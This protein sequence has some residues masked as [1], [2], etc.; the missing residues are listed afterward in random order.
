[1][2]TDSSFAPGVGLGH[3]RLAIIDLS[4]G[5]HQPKASRDG[6]LQ[7]TFNGEI[8]NFRELRQELEAKGR[9]FDT[10]SDTE[11]ILQAFEEWGEAAVSRISGQFAFALWDSGAQCLYLVRDRLGEKPLYYSVLDDGGLIFG[12]ELKALLVHP[13]CRR[14]IDPRSVED[15]FALGYVAEPR[16]IYAD[17][18]KVP[19]GGFIAFRRGAVPRTV[20][21][22]NPSPKPSQGGVNALAEELIA[23]LSRAVKAQMVR[24]VPIGAVALRWRGSQRHHRP[25]WP[26]PARLRSAAS[27][28]AS[29]TRLSTKPP[30][31]GRLRSA[32]ARCTGSRPSA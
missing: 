5:G 7:I 12:S 8:Y 27:P 21:Y 6:R 1:M 20:Q 23:R 26:R 19:A 32:M 28:S 2:A 15:F 13:R 30:M 22:W 14:N 31:P 24:D 16:S 29:R 11:V 25:G 18:A 10:K 17:V 4:P 9:H 3:R